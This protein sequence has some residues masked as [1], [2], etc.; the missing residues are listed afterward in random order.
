MTGNGNNIYFASDLHL[1]MWS[2][3]GAQKRERIFLDWLRS[4][5]NDMLELWLL[6]DVFDYWFEYR[7]VVPRGFTRFLGKLSELSDR[8]VKIHLFTGNHDIWI[9]DYL[10]N[11]IGAELHDKPLI[12][13]FGDK[14]FL[15]AHGDGLTKS[16]RGYLFLKSIFRSKFMQWCFARIHPNGSMA[17]AHWWSKKSRYSKGLEATFMGDDNEEQ[18]VFAKTHSVKNPEIDRYIFGHRHIPYDIAFGDDKRVICLGDWI[19]N[20]T[21]AKFDGKDISLEKFTPKQS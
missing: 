20:F 6:G 12:R 4:V 18:V 9:F 8:G 17:F 2:K 11:E 1:G 5:E 21:Y 19:T 14:T 15:L 16:D 13:K 7:K 3:D 10:P